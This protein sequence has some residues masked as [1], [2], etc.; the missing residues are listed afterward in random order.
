MQDLLSFKFSEAV[1]SFL[2]DVENKWHSE[3][4]GIFKKLLQ[5]FHIRNKKEEN[6]SHL[7][8][9]RQHPGFATSLIFFH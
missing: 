4:K 7:W 9:T 3:G 5:S 6:S 8:D 1:L 2:I